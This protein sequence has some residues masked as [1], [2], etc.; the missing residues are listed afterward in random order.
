M[1]TNKRI[2]GIIAVLM[3]VALIFTAV[4]TVS[5]ETMG[6]SA[7]ATGAQL[8]YP[9]KLFSENSIM[10]LNI[11]VDENAW[12][13]MLDSAAN[14]EYISCD[15]VVNGVTFT[16]VGIRPKGNSSLTQI[17]DDDT[18]DRYSFKFEF[19]HYVD[20]QTCFGLDKF[21]VNN[22]QSDATYLKEYLSYQLMDYIGVTSPLYGF[23]DIKVN[24]EDWGFYLAVEAIEGSFA[25]RNYGTDYGEIYKPEGDDMGGGGMDRQDGGVQSPGESNTQNGQIP[26]RDNNTNGVPVQPGQEGQN[27]SDSASSTASDTRQPPD[28]GNGPMGGGA[29]GS[30]GEG[31]PPQMPNSQNNAGIPTATGQEDSS[32]DNQPAPVPPEQGGF[33]GMVDG[34]SSPNGQTGSGQNT[35]PGGFDEMAPGG[36]SSSG[37]SDLIYTDDD[38]SSYADIFNNSVFDTNEQDYQRVIEALKNLNDGTD[39]EKYIDVDQVLRYF[40]ANTVLVNLDSYVSS[41]KHNYYLYEKDGQLSILPWDFNLA[42]GGFQAGNASAAVNFAIDTPVSGV[43]LSERPILDKLLEVDAYK[44][45]YHQYLQEIVTGYFDSGLFDDAINTL[46]AIISPYVQNDATAFYTYEEYQ[47]SLPMLKLFGEL[48]ALSIQGQL[49]GTIPSTSDG[50]SADSS[51]LIDASALDLS[52]LGAQGGGKDGGGMGG[53][54]PGMQSPSGDDQAGNAQPGE[55]QENDSQDEQSGGG[56]GVSPQSPGGMDFGNLPDR[57]VMAQAMQIIGS[58]GEELTEEQLSQLAGLGLTEEQIAALQQMAQGM[59]GRQSAGF[60]GNLGGGAPKDMQA[61]ATPGVDASAGNGAQEWLLIGVCFACLLG[62]LVFVVLFPR[63][64]WM[65]VK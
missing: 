61:M 31:N 35:Q 42:F 13:E 57:E 11:I 30:F 47:A 20:G 3:A 22:I 6:V 10:S 41:M 25:L 59:G 12:Q 38:S 62:G 14:E 27:G 33:P 4:L 29:G 58:S 60:G 15:V 44:E 36:Q 28:G 17:A 49:D 53:N 7:S 48:R 8:T 24:G 18:T 19:D 52:A 32:V 43:D 16:S 21:V 2:N 39:L 64:K 51:N 1:I 37:G 26:N 9:E 63:R 55:N 46:G 5:P 50:Q 34:G 40:A 54:M 56:N 45:R 23:A 65:R